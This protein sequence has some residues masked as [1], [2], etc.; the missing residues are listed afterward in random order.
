[1]KAVLLHRERLEM[2]KAILRIQRSADTAL[3]A[4]GARFTTAWKSGRSSAHVFTFES[5]SA[6]FRVL[7]PKRWEILE[8]LQQL[9]PSSLRG[10]SR[11]LERDVKRVHEDVAA[12]LDVGLVERTRQGQIHV[13]FTV[14]EADFQLRAA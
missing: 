3:A 5:P 11:S 8:R 7:T 14:I 13:P 10:L 1:M 6:L 2:T 12:L 9:G 4:M